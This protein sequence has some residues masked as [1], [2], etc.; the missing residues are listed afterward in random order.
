MDDLLKKRLDLQLETVATMQDY[1]TL[2]RFLSEKTGESVENL[3]G[4]KGGWTYKQWSD[5]LALI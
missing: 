2:L 3:R 1:T 4:S 5:R